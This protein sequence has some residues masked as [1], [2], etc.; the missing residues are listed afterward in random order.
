MK[1][2]YLDMM[3][4]AIDGELT[5]RERKHLDAYLASDDEANKLFQDL[6]L[7]GQ[8]LETIGK[9]DPSPTMK[10]GIMNNLPHPRTVKQISSPSI[11]DSISEF[12][13]AR[14]KFRLGYAFF[15]GLIAGAVIFSIFSGI[16]GDSMTLKDIQGTLLP[17]KYLN[18]LPEGVSDYFA[19]EKTSGELVF[20]YGDGILLGE[21]SIRSGEDTE[22]ILSLPRNLIHLTTVS[23]DIPGSLFIESTEDEIRIQHTGMATYQMLFTDSTR[24]E[25][26]VNLK[27]VSHG[28]TL[29]ERQLI[30]QR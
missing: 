17:A 27:I 20:R 4:K 9:E 25:G 22:I 10:A 29:T 26:P 1:T 19:F 24:F 16:S 23:R 5:P 7:I 12:F 18:S 8:Q 21:L 14:P 2:K 3:N 28:V 11:W 13:N 15:V 6:R 30:L